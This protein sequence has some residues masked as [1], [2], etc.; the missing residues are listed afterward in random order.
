MKIDL[1][2]KVALVTGSAT[3]I[4][5]AIAEALSASGARVALNH[6]GQSG[7]IAGLL[8]ALGDGARAF[9]ADVTDATAVQHMVAQV[10][11]QLGPIDILVNNAGILLEK[12]FLE[13][14]ENEWDRVIAVDLKSVFLCSQAVLRSMQPRGCGCIINVASELAYLGRAEFSA[15]CAAKAGVVGL[16][17][18]LARE[19]APA[20]RVNGI[21]PGPTDTAMLSLDQLSP[22]WRIKELAIPAGRAAGPEEIA[23]TAVFLASDF[24]RFYYGQVLSPNGGALML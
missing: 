15:Y 14:T 23:A 8:D 20:I 11:A 7:L 17:K 22:A 13:L 9:D 16:T 21:A 19:F 24:A 2:G 10:E 5:R 12:P 18:S 1:A 6:F 3:G 4:G